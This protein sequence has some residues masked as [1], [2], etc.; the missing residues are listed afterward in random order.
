MELEVEENHQGQQL[1]RTKIGNYVI[2]GFLGDGASCKVK[3]GKNLNDGK[4]YALKILKSR[5][6]KS[7]DI[8]NEV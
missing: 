4:E 1:V 2:T 3:R 6:A 8:L 7:L 5:Y